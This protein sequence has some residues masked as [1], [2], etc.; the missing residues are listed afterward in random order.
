[1]QCH[2]CQGLL[3]DEWLL[4]ERYL[5]WKRAWR[6]VNCGN[7]MDRQSLVNKQLH[8]LESTKHATSH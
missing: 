1:M 2:R 7:W 5:Y 8:A 3:V 6:C 4:D